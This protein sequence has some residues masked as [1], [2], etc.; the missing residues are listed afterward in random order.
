MLCQFVRPLWSVLL[1]LAVSDCIYGQDVSPP[2][3]QR[4]KQKGLEIKQVKISAWQVVHKNRKY[5]EVREFRETQ[6]LHLIPSSRFDVKCDHSRLSGRSSDPC[7]RA[8]G[9]QHA[10][11]KC[12]MGQMTEMRDLLATPI[13]WLRPKETRRV[14]IKSNGTVFLLSDFSS[15]LPPWCHASSIS[16]AEIF[17]LALTYSPI[18]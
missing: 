7:V 4:A 3:P 10:C 6:E 13:Y 11:F 5:V 1:I 14:E 9:Q 12:F 15:M 2:P 17:L 8:N 18:A 16:P